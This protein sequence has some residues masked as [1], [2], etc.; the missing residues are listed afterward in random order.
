MSQEVEQIGGILLEA[1]DSVC[2]GGGFFIL[3]SNALWD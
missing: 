3:G 1:V 2:F